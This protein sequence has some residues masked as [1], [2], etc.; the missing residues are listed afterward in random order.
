MWRAIIIFIAVLWTA[1]ALGGIWFGQ[2]LTASAPLRPDAPSGADEAVSGHVITG[3]PQP[4]QPLVTGEL[5]VPAR[6][7]LI[8]VLDV[9]LLSALQNHE[10]TVSMSTAKLV[11]DVR[12]QAA[13]PAAILAGGSGARASGEP[14]DDMPIP[15][16]NAMLGNSAP[17]RGSESQPA[18]LPPGSDWVQQLRAALST[19]RTQS[20]YSLAECEQRQRQAHCTPNNGWGNV[21][22]CPGFLRNLQF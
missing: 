22:E 13:D 16:L 17:S 4:P 21:A 9:P 5:G 8:N 18:P 6:N 19:C 10:S 2:A 15:G 20:R 1:S 3:L 7:D 11:A 12:P 14:A